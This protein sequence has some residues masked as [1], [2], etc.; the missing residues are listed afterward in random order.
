MK[1][2]TFGPTLKSVENDL[3][4]LEKDI[5]ALEAQSNLAKAQIGEA[6]DEARA[7]AARQS[8]NSINTQILQ[9]IRD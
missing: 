8:R 9:N 2:M 3:D 5:K 4:D 6:N 7:E 1:S